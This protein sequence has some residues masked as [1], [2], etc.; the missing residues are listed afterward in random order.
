MSKKDKGTD[1]STGSATEITRRD[2][3]GNTLL[4]SGAALLTAGSPLSVMAMGKDGRPEFKLGNSMPLPLNQ[5]D[6]GWTGYGGEGDYASANGNTHAVV[7]AAHTFRNGDFEERVAGATDSGEEYD[8]VVVGAGF[9]GCT[10]AYTF[11]K[12]KPDAVY[13]T[14]AGMTRLS[15]SQYPGIVSC[16]SLTGYVLVFNNPN[17]ISIQLHWIDYDGNLVSYGTL[18][19][20]ASLTMETYNTHPWRITDACGNC[21]AIY[22]KGSTC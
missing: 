2:F 14:A 9:A 13:T 16:N 3:V 19:P 22:V 4:G 1:D 5:L 18:A 21:L 11:L 15:C 7:N 8:L 17:T 10:A 20:G 6:K 12:A